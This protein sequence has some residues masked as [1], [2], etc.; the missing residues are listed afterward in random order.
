MQDAFA[1]GAGVVAGLVLVLDAL[2]LGGWLWSQGRK[3][4]ARPPANDPVLFSS[5]PVAAAP[6]GSGFDLDPLPKGG[7]VSS[8][9][10]CDAPPPTSLDAASVASAAGATGVIAGSARK[11][12]W[13]NAAWSPLHPFVGFQI[14]LLGAS[15]AASLGMVAPLLPHLK[16]GASPRTIAAQLDTLQNSPGYIMGLILSVFAQ[17]ALF[18][19]V[20]GAI[21]RLYGSSLAKI[22]L[23]RPTLRQVGLGLGL[24]LA[25]FF[26]ANN[27][28]GTLQQN[29]IRAISPHTLD[30]LRAASD[31]LSAEGV[32]LKLPHPSVKLLFAIGGAVAAPIGEEVFFRGLIYNML[33]A[34]T[35]VVPAIVLSGL[36]FA[37]V[38]VAPLAIAPIWIMGM[39]LAYIYE[40]TG[41]LTITI[42]MHV[43]NNSLA[44]VLLS[45]GYH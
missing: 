41:S 22:G 15:V 42:L 8:P 37:L 12:G 17:N 26:L 28:L 34:R 45:Q 25:L 36:C 29:L 7:A 43:V 4:R 30:A 6:A 11:S 16:P 3:Q 10:P 44:F 1:N 5:A 39:I 14:V 13:F 38:H 24:G 19:G 40:R 2:I 20:V 33:K 31:K 9:P 35:G 27:V 23:R 18:V 21:V 32:F